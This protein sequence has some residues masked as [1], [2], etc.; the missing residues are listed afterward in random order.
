MH[1]DQRRHPEKDI[2]CNKRNIEVDDRESEHDNRDFN[3]HR[4]QEKR[5]HSRKAEGLR[6]SSNFP[7]NDDKDGLK[8]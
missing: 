4:M 1:K 6:E 5:K 3:L 2:S 8:G 7:F